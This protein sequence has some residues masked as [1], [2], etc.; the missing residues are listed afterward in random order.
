MRADA[1]ALAF[2]AIFTLSLGASG[3]CR[4]TTCD[5]NTCQQ[6]PACDVCLIGGEPLFW[7]GGCLSFAVHE[8][9]SPLRDI[10]GESARL[11]IGNAFERWLGAS[12]AGGEPPGLAVYDYGLVECGREEYDKHGP[13]ANIWAFRDT[14][15]PYESWKIALATV[16]FN[17]QT[18]QIRDVDVE[19]NSE[20]VFFSLDGTGAVDLHSVVTHEAGHFLGL[21]H[22]CDPEATMLEGYAQGSDTLAAD[23]EIGICTVYPPGSLNDACD[24]TPQRGFTSTCAK[25]EEDDPGCAACGA[26]TSRSS[27]PGSFGLVAVALLL[28]RRLRTSSRRRAPRTARCR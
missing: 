1:F 24:P 27:T 10:D 9:G 3:F 14:D 22:S 20:D 19:L 23:D 15:W 16:R 28:W 13:N 6:D 26:A 8:E 4:T 18:G 5:E 17:T 2:S 25:F 11:A 12:C 21:A 7:P